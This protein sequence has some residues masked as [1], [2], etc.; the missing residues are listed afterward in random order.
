MANKLNMASQMEDSG[1][2]LLKQSNFVALMQAITG[3]QSLLSTLTTKVDTMQ[4]EVGRIR[5]DF[6]KICQ[7]VTETECRLGDTE[8]TVS[9]HSV[10]LHT[11]GESAVPQIQNRV[12]RETQSKE[13]PEDFGPF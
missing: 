4:L 8:D 6:D 11:A 7:R 10:S 13:Q 3:C 9:E 12:C 5:Q 2:A 1:P